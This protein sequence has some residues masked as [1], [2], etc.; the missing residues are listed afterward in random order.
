M[1]SGIEP[2]QDRQKPK[3]IKH[4]STIALD[5]IIEI[6]RTKPSRSPARHL[7]STVREILGNAQVS[8]HHYGMLGFILMTSH[9]ILVAQLTEGR[10]T[11]L[12]KVSTLGKSQFPTSKM[13]Q[14]GLRY[15]HLYFYCSC[16][17]IHLVLI[18]IHVGASRNPPESV[19]I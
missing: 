9:R 6:A 12:L 17:G 4:N 11:I 13:Y 10:R 5:E 7:P 14:S 16:T 8:I 18:M 2:P 19:G 1:S 15:M 3:S